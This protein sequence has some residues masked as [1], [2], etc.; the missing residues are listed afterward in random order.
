MHR[1]GTI[2]QEQR[3]I[4][5][6]S[7]QLAGEQ[8]AVDHGACRKSVRHA[9]LP[10]RDDR[11]DAARD[12][13]IDPALELLEQLTNEALAIHRQRGRAIRDRAR[14][15]LEVDADADDHGIELA[16]LALGLD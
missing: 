5:I 10:R 8:R 1:A 6:D 12:I 15:A 11:L 13:A 2:A 3:T 9:L 7:C 14:H 16:A 4:A